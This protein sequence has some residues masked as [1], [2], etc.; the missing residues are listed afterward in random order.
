MNFNVNTD[1]LNEYRDEFWKGLTLT[2]VIS[3]LIGAVIAGGIVAFLHFSTGLPF[4][5]AIYAAM[6]FA[7]PPIVTGFYKY[8]GYMRPTDLLKAAAETQKCGR[9]TY[10][11]NE[12]P[13]KCT[14]SMKMREE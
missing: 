13:V 14:Y 1:F 7:I 9:L 11:M 6:P 10:P 3:I 8:Q 4:D 5:T 2:E 12:V